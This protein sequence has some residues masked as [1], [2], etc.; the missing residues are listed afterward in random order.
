MTPADLE[1]QLRAW[2]GPHAGIAAATIRDHDLYPEEQ[3][4]IARA[5]PHRRAEFSTGRHCAREALRALGIPPSAIRVGRLH[6][7]VWPAGLTG[8]ITHDAGLCA[9][10][11]ARL[12]QYRGL[13]IDLLDI[14]RAVPIVESAK[15]ILNAP[16]EEDDTNPVLRFS[17]K[18]SVIKAVSAQMNRWLDFSEITIRIGESSFEASLAGFPTP[19]PGWWVQSDGLLLAAAGLKSEHCTLPP[20][21]V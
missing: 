3:A 8:S 18:E 17:A 14:A 19:V 15:A 16:G 7:P 9:A 10:V 20:T 12:T 6:G 11:V 2:F 21:C 1:T 5:V 4:H 13:G